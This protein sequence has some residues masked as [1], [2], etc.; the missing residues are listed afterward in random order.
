MKVLYLRT[1]YGFP[2]SRCEKEIYSLGKK[3]DVEFLG[4]N[5]ELSYKGLRTTKINIRD[6]TFKYEHIGI[7][8]P[9][10]EGF[11]R[12]VFPLLRF[13]AQ[14]WLY[15]NKTIS[16]Y[17]AV[18]AC[19]FDSA[20][21]LL[22]IRN[23]PP[24]IYDVF[25]YY[26]DTHKAPYIIDKMIRALE[27]QMIKKSYTT[28]ICSEE[29]E[30]QI[31]PA[32]PKKLVVIH[33]TPSNIILLKKSTKEKIEVDT[34]KLSIAYIGALVEERFLC[35]M[36]EVIAERNDCE[37]HIGGIGPLSKY[38]DEMSRNKDN[39]TFYGELKYQDVL[40]L[41]Q[42][43]DIMTAIY[44]PRTPNHK[45]AAPNKFYEALMLKKPLIMMRD[46]G[47]DS[48]VEE[49]KLGEVIDGGAETFK[50]GF[51]RALDNMIARRCEWQKMGE[52]GYKLYKE[53][54]SWDE[55]ERRLLKIYDDLES[56]IK[57][58]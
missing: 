54:F 11:K 37:L 27:R 53:Q 8:A 38:F 24:I 40:S 31:S 39:I 46:T 36:T 35:E 48:Y 15:L 26:A 56:D 21:P 49:Y 44:D 52:R 13:W 22:F 4:W 28:I 2:E 9:T 25:D 10:A 19:D 42:Q 57:K 5:R 45:Y 7:K 32:Q 34:K 20:F 47:M 50:D 58:D 6:K 1:H 12:M 17:D 14:E 18:H 23:C 55:M 41:E 3:Y 29:R 43:C 30:K 51:S 33:N 16:E